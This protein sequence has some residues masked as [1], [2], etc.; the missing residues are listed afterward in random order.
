MKVDMTLTFDVQS[1]TVFCLTDRV[2]CLTLNSLSVKFARDAVHY[3][4]VTCFL[5]HLN[6]ILEPSTK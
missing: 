3:V 4:S 2:V 6:S 5:L 1:V